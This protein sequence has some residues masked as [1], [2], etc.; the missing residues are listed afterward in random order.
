MTED[1]VVDA[2][3]SGEV[4]TTREMAKRLGVPYATFRRW[5]GRY[6]TFRTPAAPTVAGMAD[7]WDVEEVTRWVEWLRS[8]K[9]SD[10]PWWNRKRLDHNE[11]M[12]I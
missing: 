5:K 6:P 1:Q 11:E 9:P 3:I 10:R 8:T 2:F 4:V 7:I 12:A